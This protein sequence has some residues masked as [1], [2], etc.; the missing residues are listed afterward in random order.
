M[1]L[2][3]ISVSGQSNQ[4]KSRNTGYVFRKSEYFCSFCDFSSE[5]YADMK[6][7]LITHNVERRHACPV[8]ECRFV[9]KYDLKRHMRIHTGE[10][11]FVCSVCNYRANLK[12]NLVRH[13][14]TKHYC[15]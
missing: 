3:F 11:P 15:E 10:R 14:R 1:F 13:M 12:G 7:H 6:H 2:N 5:L 9:Q 4:R 8:C